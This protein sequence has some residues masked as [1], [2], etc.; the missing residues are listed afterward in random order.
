MKKII[1]LT[2]GIGSGK[3]TVSDLFSNL[4]IEVADADVA[5]RQVVLP[6]SQALL[7]IQAHFGDQAIMADGSLNRQALRKQ[8]FNNENERKWLEALLHPLIRQQ[9]QEQL[10]AAQSPYAILSSPLLLETDQYQLVDR[11]LVIDIPEELQ[12]ER[13]S[14]R[15]A[16]KREQIKAIMAA[17]MSRKERCARADDIILNDTTPQALQANVLTLHQQYLKLV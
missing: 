10:E 13:A 8:V 16:S 12:L 17:Q 15:D 7:S 6:G 4:G 11:I 9:L 14:K 5:A 1:G 2:G 3:T